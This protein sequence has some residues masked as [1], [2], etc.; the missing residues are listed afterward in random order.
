[1]AVARRVL[2]AEV[3]AILDHAR[4]EWPVKTGRSRNG[5]DDRIGESGAE[6]QAEIVGSAEYT[7]VVR[8][9]KLGGGVLAW[10]EYVEIPMSELMQSLGPDVAQALVDELE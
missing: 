3:G 6:I 8:P 10:T 9:K 4:A 7:R 5:L 1:M 2:E